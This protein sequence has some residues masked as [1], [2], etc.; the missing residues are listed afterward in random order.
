[1]WQK[2][3]TWTGVGPRFCFPC[4]PSPASLRRYTLLA[5]RHAGLAVSECWRAPGWRRQWSKASRQR[6]WWS[7]SW[8][9]VSSLET[10]AGENGSCVCCCLMAL[11]AK[12][13]PQILPMVLARKPP[14]GQL[15]AWFE[16]KHTW[17][18][19]SGNFGTS[20]MFVSGFTA[21]FRLSWE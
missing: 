12:H 1:M 6:F 4:Q 11:T 20:L 9:R 17:Y 7:E 19:S 18:W 21:L 8:P 10:A 13:N 3:H 16:L 2:T 14:F 5:A 15:P